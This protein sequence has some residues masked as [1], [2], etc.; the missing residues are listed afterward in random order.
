VDPV[1][2]VKL[3]KGQELKL[4]AIAR[5]G[6]GKDHAK[7]IPVATVVMQQVPDI[8]I[9]HALMDSLTDA[10]KEEFCASCP[11]AVFKFNP[12]DKTVREGWGFGVR[13]V[14]SNAW[15]SSLDAAAA[16]RRLSVE[17]GRVMRVATHQRLCE[18][19]SPSAQV[20]I[21][22]EE[23]YMFDNDPLLKAQELGKPDLVSI[24]FRPDYFIFRVESTGCLHAYNIVTAALDILVD[25]LNKVKCDDDA[26]R[27]L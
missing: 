21:A 17:R 24:R 4:R 11:K 2:I 12:V 26:L 3:A 20:E 25:K 9:N 6:I 18:Q 23:A 13:L 5:K 7:W 19:P 8:R 27:D 14:R 16:E 22:D 10:E 1:L 15:L